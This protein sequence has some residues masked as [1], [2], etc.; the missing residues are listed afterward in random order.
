MPTPPEISELGVSSGV[1]ALLGAILTWAG[2][3]S[4][5]DAQDLR[6]SRLEQTTVV[7]TAYEE[8]AKGCSGHF[9]RIEDMLDEVRADIK[10]VLQ[11]RRGSD[12]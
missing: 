2:F 5:L 11:H 7:V 9:N 12:G 1:G 10:E 3:K 4:R 8:H 6:I